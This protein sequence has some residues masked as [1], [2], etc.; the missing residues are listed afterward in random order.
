MKW[1]DKYGWPIVKVK[2]RKV[3]N[4][5]RFLIYVSII[6]SLR[7]TFSPCRHFGHRVPWNGFPISKCMDCGEK[8]DTYD[9][10]TCKIRYHDPSI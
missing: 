10:T 5:F 4:F 8:V 3:L 7:M 9:K 1:V 2:N 6:Q